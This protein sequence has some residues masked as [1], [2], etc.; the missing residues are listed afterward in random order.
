[1]LELA[2]EKNVACGA[3]VGTTQHALKQAESGVD[4]IISSGT[5]AGGHCGEISTM[6]LYPR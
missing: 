6:V 2:K 4:I 3:L 5:E 1:M